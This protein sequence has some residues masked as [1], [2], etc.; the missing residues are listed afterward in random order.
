MQRTAALSPELPRVC[1]L[2]LATRG[3]THL[4]TEDVEW[5]VERGINYLNWCGHRDGLSRAI[6]RMGSARKQ[7]VVAAQFQARTWRDAEREFASMLE[8]LA[9]K[10]STEQLSEAK[11]RVENWRNGSAK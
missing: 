10:M 3:N 1:R 9:S 7:V 8:E 6:A 4:K 11:A 2:G 5:A